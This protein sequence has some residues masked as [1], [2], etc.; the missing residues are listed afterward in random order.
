MGW[1]ENANRR[2]ATSPVGW[3]FKLDGSGHVSAE[4]RPR[5]MLFAC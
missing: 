5:Q 2:I 3:W 1:I 4:P